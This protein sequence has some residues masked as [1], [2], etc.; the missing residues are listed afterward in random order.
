MA[1]QLA[2]ALDEEPFYL[3]VN[4]LTPRGPV[5]ADRIRV[6][7]PRIDPLD[8]WKV[9]SGLAFVSIAEAKRLRERGWL[10]R[11]TWPG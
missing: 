8:R 3:R 10:T 5:E 11:Q 6:N 7:D 1:D 9:A 4:A 2:L